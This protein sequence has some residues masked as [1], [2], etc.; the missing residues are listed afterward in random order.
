MCLDCVLISVPADA[1]PAGKPLVARQGNRPA[2][3]VTMTAYPPPPEVPAGM[4]LTH[5][6]LYSW[7]DPPAPVA[8]ARDAAGALLACV[9]DADRGWL[10]WKPNDVAEL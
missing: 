4:A 3:G 9:W 2:P 1:P 7:S 8:M 6:I 10:G 5:L